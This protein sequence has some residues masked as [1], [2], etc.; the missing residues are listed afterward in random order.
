[1]LLKTGVHKNKLKNMKKPH[2]VVIGAGLSGLTAAYRIESDIENVEVTILEANEYPGGRMLTTDFG[3]E[4]GGESIGFYYGALQEIAEE[5]NIAIDAAPMT[6]LNKSF[7]IAYYFEE[8]KEWVEQ[9]DWAQWK[10][11]PLPP[12]MR[13]LPPIMLLRDYVSRVEQPDF[14]TLLDDPKMREIAGQSLLDFLQLQGAPDEVLPFIESNFEVNDDLS[15]LS[16]LTS[17]LKTWI[18]QPMMNS[19]YYYVKGG[20]Q[21]LPNRLASKLRQVYFNKSVESVKKTNTG[22]HEIQTADGSKY[23]CDYVIFALPA[24]PMNKITIEPPLQGLQKEAFDQIRYTPSMKIFYRV[25]KNFWEDDKL[26]IFMWTNTEIN[27]VIPVYDKD[28]RENPLSGPKLWGIYA[29]ANGVRAKQLYDIQKSGGDIGTHCQSILERIRPSM[30]DALEFEEIVD[31]GNKETALGAFHFYEPNERIVDY[32]KH[33][34]TP[35]HHRHFACEHTEYKYKGFEAAAQ[36]G[37]RSA[38]EV[39][40]DIVNK[41]VLI[42]G[43]GNLGTVLAKQ[44]CAR[45][46]DTRVTTTTSA[47]K[48]TLAEIADDVTV[49]KVDD[50]PENIKALEI[51]MA[52]RDVV[53]CLVGPVPGK[54]MTPQ[55]IQ[56]HYTENLLRPAQII[57]DIL[58]QR[59]ESAPHIIFSSSLSVY[60]TGDQT[61][62]NLLT[63]EIDTSPCNPSAS[64]YDATEKVY[65]DSGL[66]VTI[67]RLGALYD[68][69][70]N[71]FANQA[72]MAVEKMGGVSPFDP[73]GLLNKIGIWDAANAIDFVVKGKHYGIFN[74]CDEEQVAI[75]DFFDHLCEQQELKPIQH[76]GMIK[77]VRKAV[78]FNKI[79]TL[80]FNLTPPHLLIIGAG[81]L[82]SCL[83]PKALQ[84]GYRVTLTTTTPEKV[85]R[86]REL[87]DDKAEVIVVEGGDPQAVAKAMEDKDMIVIAVAPRKDQLKGHTFNEHFYQ[88]FGETY[89]GTAKNVVKAWQKMIHKPQ[90]IY[91]SSHSVYPNTNGELVDENTYPLPRHRVSSIL[92]EAESFI[93]DWIPDST[94][95]RMGWLLSETRNWEKTLHLWKK[96]LPNY[97]IP[98]QSNTVANMVHIEDAAG[99][100]LYCLNKK[101]T[102]KYN[103]CNDAH[104]TWGELCKNVA[105]QLKIEPPKWN[106]QIN[107]EWF[108]GNHTISNQKIKDAGFK[109]K[110]PDEAGWT[111]LRK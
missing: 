49:L 66:P 65:L 90:V 43:C 108:E 105:Q 26:P 110:Y 19:K 89:K 80:G 59:P 99:S 83:V 29:I 61:Q 24:L 14:D 79:R 98:G 8:F 85:D 107:D 54:A 68:R 32:Y 75:K 71:A 22:Q 40:K 36:A 62:D 74:V 23:T 48:K 20:N 111:F 13:A 12:K 50:Q 51:A 57:T 39:A 47:K 81:E 101:L 6:V 46:Y 7:N 103:V 11:N 33:I 45:Y 42:I 9:K 78:S 27:F 67:L 25:K 2:V 53:V 55:E 91:V 109:F 21:E 18:T 69:E 72:R 10:N 64:L 28:T 35:S 77:G 93:L 16:A 52:D 102:G 15:K 31:W 94:V 37:L 60:G 56:D 100:I 86:L 87:Y 5:V 17:V 38:R 96:L 58:K 104:P 34:A 63:E 84:Q 76:M 41:R 92:R 1:V 88:V 3:G 44:W 73:E 82:S 30:K 70:K 4:A 106:S 97:E 95:L